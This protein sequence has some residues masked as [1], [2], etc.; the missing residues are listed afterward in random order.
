[1]EPVP[2]GGHCISLSLSLVLS[3]METLVMLACFLRKM[4]RI[5]CTKGPFVL[6]CFEIRTGSVALLQTLLR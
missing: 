1:M 6:F 3:A 4:K 2:W 5:S